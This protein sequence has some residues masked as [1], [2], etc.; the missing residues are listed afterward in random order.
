MA[1]KR[2]KVS[3]TVK[4]STKKQNTLNYLKRFWQ[5]LWYDDS[6]IS[7]ITL[8]VVAYL[9]IRF[10][11]FP[12]LGLT[13]GTDFPLVAVISSS[14]DHNTVKGEI[15]GNFPDNYQNNI[16]GFWEQC[17]SWYDAR[18]ITITQ[19]NNFPLKKGFSKGDIIILRGKKPES[20]NTGDVIVFSAQDPLRKPDPIIHRVV[21]A[22]E[23]G[24][25]YFQTKGDHNADIW[26][27]EIIQESRIHES[28]VLGVAWFRLP[29]LGYVKIWFVE[30]WMLLKGTIG[31]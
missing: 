12:I 9:A 28:R 6:I 15:C 25:Y 5:F 31:A 4:K 27:D 19:F 18:E 7:W 20:I 13:L 10:A 3:N 29:V 30:V 1:K 24:D 8:V 23:E 22:K 21:A 26:A 2:L 11:V 16:E 14:M 17:G